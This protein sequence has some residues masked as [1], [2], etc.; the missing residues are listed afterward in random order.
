MVGDFVRRFSVTIFGWD[1]EPRGDQIFNSEVIL[2]P[3]SIMQTSVPM[4]KRRF[5]A[6]R[7][8]LF[9]DEV[10]QGSSIKELALRRGTVHE[11]HSLEMLAQQDGLIMKIERKLFEINLE[12][13]S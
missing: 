9:V 2:R 8:G 12:H 13:G 7:V 4:E 1:V 5:L 10:V 6:V 3:N 11:R